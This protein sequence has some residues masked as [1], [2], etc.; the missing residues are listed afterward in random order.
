MSMVL[1]TQETSPL[2]MASAYGTFAN[3]GTHCSPIAILSVT[4]AD[5]TSIVPP[6]ANCSPELSTATTNAVNYSLEQVLTDGGAKASRLANRTAAGKTGTTND[7]K[8]AWFVGYT[9]EVSTAIWM[10]DP[11]KVRTLA[12]STINGTFYRNVYGSDIPAP[13]W[14]RIMDQV[15]GGNPDVPLSAAIAPAQLGQAPAPKPPA[16]PAPAAPEQPAPPAAPEG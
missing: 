6:A 9:R 7:N 10:G 14:K 16:A 12:G 15:V 11:L 1:G 13:T 3:E 8:D 5:G 4:K 2:S